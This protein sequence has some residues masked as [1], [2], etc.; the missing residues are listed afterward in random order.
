MNSVWGVS[1]LEGFY[2]GYVASPE[3]VRSVAEQE[4]DAVNTDDHPII[5]FGFARHVGRSGTFK[6]D[7]LRELARFRNEDI[8]TTMTGSLDWD[9][10]VELREARNLMFDVGVADGEYE[11]PER[12]ARNQARIAYFAK[13]LPSTYAHWTAQSARPAVRMDLL[14]VAESMAEAGDPA[15]EIYA[16]QLAAA[17]PTE[18]AV[19]MSR[20]RLRQGDFD[21]A[22]AEL[23]RAFRLYREDPWPWKTF[24]RRSL[25]LLQEIGRERPDDLGRALFDDLSEPFAVHLLNQ[26]RLTVRASLAKGVDFPGLC[27]QAYEA[28]E[29]W[30]PWNEG[31]LRSRRDCY[32]A[33]GHRLA[34]RAQSELLEF[35]DQGEVKMWWGL[36]PE[37][38]MEA[39]EEEVPEAADEA[40]GGR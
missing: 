25:G 23:S 18:A 39:P 30:V 33:V 7:R 28:F 22:A 27:A 29:P 36:L 31:F 19:V 4:G 24:M 15:A 17:Q 5:E 3:F 37:S 21:A 26:A 11:N 1:G 38:E 6:I 9:R 32:E 2:T 8:P 35:L 14:L 10:V 12:Q 20:L 16:R 40:L 13:D 34:R